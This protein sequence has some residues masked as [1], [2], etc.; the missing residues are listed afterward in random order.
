MRLVPFLFNG[1]IIQNYRNKLGVPFIIFLVVMIMLLVSNTYFAEDMHREILV[2]QQELKALKV[3]S[4]FLDARVTQATTR[5]EM[6][7][8]VKRLGLEESIS[9]LHKITEKGGKR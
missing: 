7:R 3:E 1:K 2:K 9:P 6:K 4:T 8:R 5:T